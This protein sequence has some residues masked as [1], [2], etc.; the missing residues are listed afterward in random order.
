MQAMYFYYLLN[1]RYIIHQSLCLVRNFQAL[2]ILKKV[3]SLTLTFLSCSYLGEKSVGDDV[4]A[5]KRQQSFHLREAFVPSPNHFMTE[6]KPPRL[7]RTTTSGW[8]WHPPHLTT[9]HRTMPQ[10]SRHQQQKADLS[11][12]KI[13]TTPTTPVI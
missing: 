10:Q 9:N 6:V 11:W 2:T 4:L 8:K 3:T 1:A 12:V 5:T 7:A 13:I